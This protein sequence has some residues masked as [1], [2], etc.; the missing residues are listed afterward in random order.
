MTKHPN[1]PESAGI[2]TAAILLGV[3]AVLYVG[4]E[5]LVP[6]AFAITLAMIIASIVTLLQWLRLG[7]IPAALLVIVASIASVGA[8]SG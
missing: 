2:R 5:I 4:R 3:V 1:G 8:I 7:R 6:L